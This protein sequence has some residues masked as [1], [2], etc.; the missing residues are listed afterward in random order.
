VKRYER[1]LL[2]LAG[3]TTLVAVLLAALE[4]DAGRQAERA[5]AEGTRRGWRSSRTS[6]E[7]ASRSGSR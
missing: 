2:V 4:A 6:R 3:L 1:T 5:S 7:P